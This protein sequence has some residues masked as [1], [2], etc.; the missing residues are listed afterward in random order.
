MD[1][2]GE[3]TDSDPSLLSYETVRQG[4]S[5]E[6]DVEV[7]RTG[8]NRS[9]TAASLADEGAQTLARRSVRSGVFGGFA[10]ADDFERVMSEAHNQ[11]VADLRDHERRLGVL[12]DKAH[13]AASTFDDMEQRNA[14]A[15]LAVAWQ[16]T[17]T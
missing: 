9:Y 12:G 14:E 6:I 3:L 7:M 1:L 2:T 11:H 8:A 13:V 5:V 16:I 10:A 4:A 17:Q 15:L